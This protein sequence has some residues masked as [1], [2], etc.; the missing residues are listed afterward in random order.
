MS[1]I[2]INC[3]IQCN[4]IQSNLIQSKSTQ[5]ES[6]PLIQLK[7]IQFNTIRINQ[8]QFKSFQFN[9]THPTE[10]LRRALYTERAT[11]TAAK[12]K[13]EEMTRLL[14]DQKLTIN[15]LNKRNA[16]SG[17]SSKRGQAQNVKTSIDDL[18]SFLV[19]RKK[20]GTYLQLL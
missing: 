9:P 3:L 18:T 13:N 11:H 2:Q 10:I 15:S 19:N 8:T 20:R 12:L 6:I 16:D 7:S 4:R 14:L 17:S 1:F 5:F